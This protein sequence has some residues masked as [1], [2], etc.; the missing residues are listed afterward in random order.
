MSWKTVQVLAA[1]LAHPNCWFSAAFRL[2][3]TIFLFVCRT[4]NC[5]PTTFGNF[6]GLGYSRS[7]SSFIPSLSSV[8]RRDSVTDNLNCFWLIGF[9]FL[10][11]ATKQCSFHA[12]TTEV[13]SVFQSGH[14]FPRMF[15]R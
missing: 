3:S 9:S 12:F 11:F 6:R 14:F 4:M 1:F 7:S 15:T 2:A 10:Y 5:S 13:F 8:N